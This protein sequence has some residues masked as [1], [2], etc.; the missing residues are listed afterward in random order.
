MKCLVELPRETRA[1]DCARIDITESVDEPIQEF[2][3]MRTIRARLTH[4]TDVDM[5]VRKPLNPIRDGANETQFTQ[6][7]RWILCIG[8]CLVLREVEVLQQ[9]VCIRGSHMAVKT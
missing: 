1:L 3:Q 7:T 8:S 5:I 9:Q 6:D 2:P 4:L